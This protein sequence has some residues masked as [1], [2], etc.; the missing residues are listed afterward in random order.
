MEN[1]AVEG[2]LHIFRRVFV[3]VHRLFLAVVDAIAGDAVQVDM[4]FVFLAKRD[5]FINIFYHFLVNLEP[6]VFRCPSPV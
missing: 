1:R 4:N 5:D 3:K 6:V 2:L